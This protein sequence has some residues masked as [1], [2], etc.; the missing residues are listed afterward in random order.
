M[1]VSRRECTGMN[2]SGQRRATDATEMLIP[3]NQIK[4]RQKV[5]DGESSLI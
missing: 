2:T 3:V 4:T 5:G 1:K